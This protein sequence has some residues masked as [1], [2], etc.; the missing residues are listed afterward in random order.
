[1]KYFTITV[2]V[3]DSTL[4]EIHELVSS[5]FEGETQYQTNTGRYIKPEVVEVE[6]VTTER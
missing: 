6:E 3:E 1:M 5:Y 4:N 2:K